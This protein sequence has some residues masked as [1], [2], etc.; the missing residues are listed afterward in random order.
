MERAIGFLLT[1]QNP[2]GS[3]GTSTVESLFEIHYSNASF[4]AWKL[5]GGALSCRA[6]MKVDETPERRAAL[7]RAFAYILDHPRPRRGN[8]WDID[9]NWA[10]LCVFTLLVDATGDARFQGEPWKSKIDAAGKE[11]AQHLVDNQEPL[12]GWGYY[13]GPVISRRPTWSTSFSTAMVIPALVEARALGWPIEA[14]VVDKAIEYVRRCALPNGAY[15]YDLN[16]IPRVD[17][18]EHINDVKGSLGRIQVCNWALRE[19]GVKTVTDDKIR[20]GLS[21]FFEHHKFL[22]VAR[23]RPIPHEAYYA[24]AGYFYFFGHY[25][26]AE[27]INCLPPAEREAWHAKLRPHLVK[28][29]WKDGS[30]VDF[31]GSFYCWTASTSFSVLA[32]EAGLHPERFERAPAA[33]AKPAREVKAEPR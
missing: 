8:H 7:E 19:A 11:Y 4:Y 23:L 32:L 26:A 24:N 28:A 20:W 29:Q 16:P 5:A 6:L 1:K 12:G 15:E 30:S 13:E 31:P 2:D 18:G 9:N 10:A 17:G 3:W 22:D 25:F 14:Q 27:A 33:P 21:Q